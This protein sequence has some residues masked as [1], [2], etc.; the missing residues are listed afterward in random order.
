M[1]VLPITLVSLF[2]LTLL[3]G[4]S[5]WLINWKGDNEKLSPYESGFEPLG[6]AR[7]RFAILYWIIIGLNV[8]KMKIISLY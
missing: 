7:L 4:L 1:A 5:F 6:D 3:Y 2:V 8:K